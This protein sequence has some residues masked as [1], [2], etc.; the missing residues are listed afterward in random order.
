M[1]FIDILLMKA[2]YPKKDKQGVDIKDIPSEY[3]DKA[4]EYKEKLKEAIAEI[5]DDLVEKYLNGEQFTDEEI[6]RGVRKC[7]QQFKIVPL[8]CGS[9]N[10]GIGVITLLK[11]VIK[12][13]PSPLFVGE[14]LGFNPNDENELI[15]RNPDVNDPFTAF[16]YKTR[17]DQYAGKFSYFRVRSGKAIPDMELIN[18]SSENKIKLSHIYSI[19]GSKQVQINELIAGDIGVVTKLDDVNTGDTLHDPK[20][21]IK[22]P[23]LKLPKTIYYYPLNQRIKEM[24]IK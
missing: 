20:D 7:T 4:K 14:T 15:A 9:A 3:M 8:V 13:L 5:D 2:L 16:V 21:P 17:L 24:K 22:L 18:A 12:F 19:M 10:K 23:P 6:A 1:V 11:M